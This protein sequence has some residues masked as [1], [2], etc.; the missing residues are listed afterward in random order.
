MKIFKNR[1]GQI[2]TLS[3]ASIGA[4]NAALPAN[5]TSAL[6]AAATDGATMGAAVLVAIV[7]IYALKLLRR[8]L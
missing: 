6:E 1:Y 2:V 5:V 4:A 8:A 7:G 3:F